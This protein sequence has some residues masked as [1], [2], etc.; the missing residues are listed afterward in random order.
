M[1][2]ISEAIKSYLKKKTNYAVLITGK[3]GAG[4]S[5]Y[6]KN[7]LAQEIESVENLKDAKKYKSIH[8]SLFGLKSIED[9]QSQIFISIYPLFQDKTFKISSGLAKSVLRGL[10]S[11]SKLG[12]LDDYISD[13]NVENWISYD[14][15]VICFD[16][17]E[18]KSPMLQISDLIGFINSLV[19]NYGAKIILIANEGEIEDETYK[20]YKEKVVGITLE[21]VPDFKENFKIIVEERYKKAGF[22]MFC[23]FLEEQTELLNKL[24]IHC[25]ENLRTLIFTMDKLHDIFALIDKNIPANSD[26]HD[27]KPLILRTAMQFTFAIAIEYKNGL[28]TYNERENLNLPNTFGNISDIYFTDESKQSESEKEDD[29]QTR[30]IKKHYPD[31]GYIFYES[32]YAFITA[33]IPFDTSK[34]FQ[35]VN[36]AYR[37]EENEIPDYQKTFNQLNYH[38]F[39]QLDGKTYRKLTREMLDYAEQG[40]YG[41]K[42]YLPIFHF[43]LRFDNLLNYNIEK[44]KA[45]IKRG[46]DIAKSREK[47]IRGIGDYL[48]GYKKSSLKEDHQKIREYI[49][50]VNKS[51]EEEEKSEQ[52][53]EFLNQLEIDWEASFKEIMNYD[54][55]W[56]R[57]PF[58]QDASVHKI[59]LFLNRAEIKQLQEFMR[60]VASRYVPENCEELKSELIFLEKLSQKL[61]PK[62]KVRQKKTL[63]NY[64][65]NEV[66]AQ[67]NTVI[68]N[69]KSTIPIS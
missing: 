9:I 44:L 19:E 56:Y 18:R 59:Y 38:H 17:L 46:I 23:E 16:D 61:A 48:D 14:N 51:L 36:E 39:N 43:A 69:M 31:E 24:I 65:L 47:S 41:L 62:S 68:Q 13:Q 60:V 27:V 66:Y 42:E 21:Y 52:I 6:Y 12:K 53:H 2:S 29:Y 67:V 33:G 55:N 49:I 11:V 15:L 28:I 8:I 57:T 37:I 64:F 5:Y 30:F 32:I 10:L 50:E 34:F 26:N 1:K 25:E 22:S 45:R 58:L 4:K 7:E 20:K 3:W 63:E 40:L 54:S 35:E